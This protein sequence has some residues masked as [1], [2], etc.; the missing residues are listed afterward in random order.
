MKVSALVILFGVVPVSVAPAMAHDGHATPH[1]QNQHNPR[2]PAAV[3]HRTMVA[4]QVPKV[5]LVREDAALVELASEIGGHE[6]VFLNFVYTTCTSVCPVMTDTLAQMQQELGAD[7]RK[8]RIVS[9]S[10]DPEHDTPARLRDY[11]RQFNAG[12]Q[13]HFY[14]GT[15]EASRAVQKAF[16]SDTPDKMSHQVATFYRAAHAAKWVRLEGFVSAQELV[17]LYRDGR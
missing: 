9:I 4:Y 17:R 16:A 2:Q 3:V 10:I 8:I 1:A 6:P 5:S 12:P 15:P 14:T 7:A 11:A 13:W